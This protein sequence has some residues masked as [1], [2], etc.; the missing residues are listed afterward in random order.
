MTKVIFFTDFHA[1]IFE[2]FATPDPEFVNDRFR[3]QI[4]TLHKVYAIAREEDAVVVFGGDLFHKR[5]KVDD[6]VFNCIYDVIATYT[7]IPTY[8]IRGNHDSRNNTT[9]S[10]HWLKTFGYL[11]H[12]TVFAKPGACMIGPDVVLCAVPYSDDTEFLKSEIVRFAKDV[13]QS[14]N[15][16]LLVG[17]IGVDGS[18]VGKYSHRLEGAFKVG[19]LFPD[20]FDYVALGHYHKRQF[21]GGTDNVFYAGN[22]IQT[23]FSDEGQDKGVFLIDFENMGKPQFIPIENKKFITLTEIDENTQELVDNN[24]VRFILPPNKAQEVAIFKEATDNIRVEIQKEYK[25]ET[26]ISISMESN[27]E[28]IVAAYTNE[29]YPE[30]TE[31][32]LDILKEAMTQ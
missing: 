1:H 27:E 26:R 18:E 21:L 31:L 2:D 22:T 24:Y 14:D 30:A 29:F 7:D 5:A 25:T 28:Q 9:D 3:A 8:L 10:P 12:V 20:V 11:P 4:M 16:S 23:S 6:I 17:H 19:D 32:A 13:E 15:Y